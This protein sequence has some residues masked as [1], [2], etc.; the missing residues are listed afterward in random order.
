MPGRQTD[1]MSRGEG[2]W[3]FRQYPLSPYVIDVGLI[4]YRAIS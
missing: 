4:D 1:I 3:Y 2:L